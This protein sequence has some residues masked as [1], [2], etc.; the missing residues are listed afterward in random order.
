MP[1]QFFKAG[2]YNLYDRVDMIDEGIKTIH[3]KNYIYF[4]FTSRLNG[5]QR[6]MGTQDSIQKYTY[7]L[8]L[9]ENGRTLVITF[10]CPMQVKEE[11]QE[12]ARSVMA[13]VRIK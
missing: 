13:S 10:S 2:I 7:V 3:K 1:K 5:D 6:D 9:I 12:T 4:E 11:W 8:Y